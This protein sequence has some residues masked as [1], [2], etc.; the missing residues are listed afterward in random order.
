MIDIGINRKLYISLR[1]GFSKRT[2]TCVRL[3]LEN[4]YFMR[5]S[6]TKNY[7]KLYKKL[8]HQKF[9]DVGLIFKKTASGREKIASKIV[10]SL[11]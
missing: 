7:S 5:T 1:Y 11:F 8:L 3:L 9:S 4:S 6:D 10:F 2:Y